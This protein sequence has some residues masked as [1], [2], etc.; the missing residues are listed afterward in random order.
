MSKEAVLSK[1]FLNRFDRIHDKTLNKF[2]Y[3]TLLTGKRKN[4]IVKSKGQAQAIAFAKI[5]SLVRK[6]KIRVTTRRFKKRQT[7]NASRN[8]RASRRSAQKMIV[9]K[10]KKKKKK[11]IINMAPKDFVVKGKSKVFRPKTNKQLFKD[12]FKK[13]TKKGYVPPFT[14]SGLKQ[15][16]TF[17]PSGNMRKNPVRGK[18]IVNRPGYNF[19]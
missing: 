13:T 18:T 7:N 4:V 3:R 1:R 16:S 14:F 15:A 8:E 10:K 6:T 9:P 12:A 17:T 11:I 2:H 19:H 5:N